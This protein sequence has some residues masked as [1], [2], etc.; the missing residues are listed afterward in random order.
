MTRVSVLTPAGSAAIATVAV[1]GPRAWGLT[2]WLFRPAGG[3]TL[4]DAPEPHRFWVGR[5]ADGDEVVLAVRAV[6]PEVCVELHGHG[7]R[8]VVR[9]TVEAF[10]ARGCV[11]DGAARSDVWELLSRAPTLRTANILLDQAHGAFD[12]AVRAALVALDD[13]T[14]ARP[15]LAELA[16]FAPIGRHLVEP[17]KVVVAGPPNVGKSSLV[18][19]LAGYQR[20]VVSPTP[21]TTRD[22]VTTALAF[23]GWPVELA[24]TAG[25]RDAAGLEAEGIE[26]ARARLATADLVLWVTDASTD[27]P[28]WPDDE[29]S[30]LVPPPTTRWV[31]VLNKSDCGLDRS[32]NQPP[33]AVPV[34][35][36]TGDGIPGLASWIAYRLVP[37]SLPPGAAVPY[38]PELAETVTRAHAALAFGQSDEAA[39][40]LR[41]CVT[42]EPPAG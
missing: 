10:T 8:R 33:G 11:E 1:T 5:L 30:A 13:D 38:T 41:S 25:L 24:D 32:P 7:G 19:A 12:R 17:W 29:T 14:D 21:G 35:A 2:R 18:N 37:D 31:L 16:R 36:L 20:A 9:Q 42:A 4:P 3:R 39:R 27:D 28:E 26:R 23:D 6:T 34:S 40:L 15:L 22:V